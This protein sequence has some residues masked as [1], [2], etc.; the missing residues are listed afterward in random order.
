MD[1]L[2]VDP[3]TGDLWVSLLVQ[4][5]KVK[6]HYKDHSIAVPSKCMRLRM[7]QGAELPFN[8]HTLEEVL[9]S[10]GEDG[11]MGTITSCLYT[12]QRLVVGSLAQDM[13]LCD[14]KHLMY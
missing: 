14:V 9:S 3:E 7:D 2:F 4:P 13:M 5:L 6:D 8:N 1:N 12:G 11:V 10:T